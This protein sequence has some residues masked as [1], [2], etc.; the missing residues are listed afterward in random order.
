VLLIDGGCHRAP[1]RG[2]VAG[3]VLAGCLPCRRAFTFFPWVMIQTYHQN[4][5]E[6][7]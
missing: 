2:F 6:K 3:G 4:M 7:F 1:F 5:A